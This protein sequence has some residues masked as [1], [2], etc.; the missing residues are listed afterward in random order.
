MSSRLTRVIIECF[1]LRERALPSGGRGRR[2]KS[3]HPDH[4]LLFFQRPVAVAPDCLPQETL[5]DTLMT[6][7]RSQNGY[8]PKERQPL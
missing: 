7:L 8:D 5:L 3:S 6:Q 2:F 4:L 1:K